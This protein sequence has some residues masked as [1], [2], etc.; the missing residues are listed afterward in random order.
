MQEVVEQALELYNK[1]KFWEAT[2]AAYAALRA[3][4][5]AWQEFQAEL[6]EWDVTLNDGLEGL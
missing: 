1:Q 4:P 5:A 2:N 3:D 6:A